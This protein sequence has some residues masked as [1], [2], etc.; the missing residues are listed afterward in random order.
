MGVEH[1]VTKAWQEADCSLHDLVFARIDP[2]SNEFR[3]T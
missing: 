2:L 1:P 3:M